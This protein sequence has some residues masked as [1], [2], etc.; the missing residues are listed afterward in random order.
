MSRW[1]GRGYFEDRLDDFGDDIEAGQVQTGALVHE[2]GDE[3]G[4]QVY[5]LDRQ[6][7][8]P[9]VDCVACVTPAYKAR[10]FGCGR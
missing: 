7:D 8:L 3:L 2:A 4:P 9:G 5:H 6:A 1:S 10:F